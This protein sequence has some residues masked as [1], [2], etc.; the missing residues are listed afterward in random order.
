MVG[1]L[2]SVTIKNGRVF[3]DHKEG[4]PLKNWWFRTVVLE[5]TL[6]SPLDYKEIKPVNLKGNQPWIFIGRTDSE[7]EVVQYF[8][9]QM[10]RASSLEKTLMLRKIK[11]KRRRRWQRMRWLHSITDSMDVSLS[12]LW[13]MVKDRKAQHAAVHGIARSQAQLRN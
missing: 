7:A 5:K 1:T 12:K 4:W 11:C 13:E 2:G 9:H 8:G 3:R 6:E 10:W